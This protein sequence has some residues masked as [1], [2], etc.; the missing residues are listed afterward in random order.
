MGA[1]VRWNVA[2]A[3]ACI[4]PRV[5][6]P[7]ALIVHVG[8]ANH[9]HTCCHIDVSIRIFH[10]ARS[11]SMWDFRVPFLLYVSYASHLR[12]RVL[13]RLINVL[14]GHEKGRSHALEMVLFVWWRSGA[15]SKSGASVVGGI[16][17]LSGCPLETDVFKWWD[18][19][20]CCE[21]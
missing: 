4:Q 11:A 13:F 3:I 20:T 18:Y 9:S 6:T 12:G 7:T 5:Q 17:K 16:E 1:R 8:V 10:F 15:I 19:W 14:R 2:I 21:T